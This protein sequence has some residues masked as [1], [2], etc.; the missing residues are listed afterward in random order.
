VTLTDPELEARLRAL[1]AE[2]PRRDVTPTF[3]DTVR[4]RASRHR[5]R[6]LAVAAAAIA[7]LLVT[8]G[9]PILLRT[10]TRA[11]DAA[12]AGGST[13]GQGIHSH[14]GF[15]IGWLPAGL[16]LREDSSSSTGDGSLWEG[17]SDTPFLT[18]S[19]TYMLIAPTAF[20]SQFTT[21]QDDA[22]YRAGH[23]PPAPP[24]SAYA[25]D[26]SPASVWVSVT[27]HP[28]TVITPATL[29]TLVESANAVP[30]QLHVD[31][32]QDTVGDRPAVL[33]T[34]EGTHRFYDLEPDR[35][36][37]SALIWTN[38]DGAAL[39]VETAGPS[40]VDA[41][42]LHRIADSLT[43]DHMV[44]VPRYT[45][46]AYPPALPDAATTAA[47]TTAVTD[48]FNPGT[49]AQRWT[50]AVQDGP[51][52]LAVSQGVAQQFPQLAATIAVKI[53][54]LTQ[55]APGTVKVHLRM[56]FTDPSAVPGVDTSDLVREV[57][58]IR[59]AIGWQ[60]SR[61]SYCDQVVNLHVPG[62]NCK[63]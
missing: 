34:A 31:L 33:L 39:S 28:D 59:T 9:T 26:P 4:A 51:A 15:S 54:D 48:A 35:D 17:W 45:P 14:G 44:T 27:W 58:V 43:L 5:S 20:M 46:P 55:V 40:P 53:V 16:R 63:P 12:A 25:T 49:P 24:P 3:T 36:Y 57:T 10:V 62:L 60:L 23:A 13:A 21:P 11:S 6:A 37:S 8:V 52:L 22:A 18:W 61:A 38:R 29:A 1:G 42:V 30:N 47:V 2:L 32:A 7:V 50:T 41:A 19:R 56:S